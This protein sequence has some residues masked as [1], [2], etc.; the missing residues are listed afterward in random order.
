MRSSTFELETFD[1]SPGEFHARDFEGVGRALWLP[2][3]R[4]R[5]TLV[6]G[7]SQRDDDLNREELA[8]REIDVARRRTGGGAVLVSSSDVIWFDVVLDASDPLWNADVRRSFEWLG[9]A[10]RSALSSLGVDAVMHD[11]P[12]VR[13][14]WSPRVC[15]A[16]LGPGELTVDGR[17]AVGISQRRTRGSARFQVAVLRRWDPASY[18]RLFIG[19][20]ADSDEANSDHAAMDAAAVAIERSPAEVISAV[21]TA[22]TAA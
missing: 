15:F 22:I 20:P 18:R 13:T 11:G 10:C 17:K 5:Q 21:V 14:T 7:S 6:L 9:E 12:L 19:S 2:Q 3:L 16:G 4:P 8:A 1:E